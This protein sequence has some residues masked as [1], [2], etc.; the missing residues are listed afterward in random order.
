MQVTQCFT[1]NVIEHLHKCLAVRGTMPR[2]LC[3]LCIPRHHGNIGYIETV[4][5]IRAMCRHDHLGALRRCLDHFGHNRQ[6]PGMQA[7]FWFVDY[8]QRPR[9]WI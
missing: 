2:D 8:H 6:Q 9:P 1:S 3:F 4:E 5:Q 7:Q